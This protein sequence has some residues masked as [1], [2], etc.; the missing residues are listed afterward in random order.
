MVLYSITLA[1]LSEELRDAD[2]TLLSPFYVDDAALHRSECQSKAQ[3]RLLM[4]RG[5]DQI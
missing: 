3:L 4:D 5:K 2:T 1:P